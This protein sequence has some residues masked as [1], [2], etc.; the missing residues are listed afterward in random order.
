MTEQLS[1]VSPMEQKQ[2]LGEVIYMKIVSTQPELAGKITG[3]LLEMDN[4]EL[5]ALL[6]SDKAMSD[7]VQEALKVLQEYS[8]QEV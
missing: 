4:S 8:V 7:K 3:M 5:L 2:L 6:E 1:T